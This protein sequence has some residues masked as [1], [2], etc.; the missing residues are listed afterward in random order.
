MGL[1]CSK[2]GNMDKRLKRINIPKNI[3]AD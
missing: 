2:L 3:P 1:Y